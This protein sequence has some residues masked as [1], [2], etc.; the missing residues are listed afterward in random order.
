[1]AFFGMQPIGGL[2]VG[3]A[4]HVIGAPLTLLLQGIATLAI[5][6]IFFPFLRK[7]ILLRKHRIKMNQVEEGV[8]E[9]T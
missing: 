6:I 9:N 5:A 1:M 3:S 7:D 4:A 8:I 2:I